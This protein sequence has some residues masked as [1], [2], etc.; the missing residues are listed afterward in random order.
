[1]FS[2]YRIR[3]IMFSH[4][5]V[6]RFLFKCWSLFLEMKSVRIGHIY[7]VTM[8]VFNITAHEAIGLIIFDICK[9]SNMLVAEYHYV[10]L[11]RQRKR[12]K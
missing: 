3:I 8:E 5:F 7:Y 2:V 1:M 9:K 4:K 10:N 12:L 6:F 11:A